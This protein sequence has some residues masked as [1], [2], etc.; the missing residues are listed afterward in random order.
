[1]GVNEKVKSVILRNLYDKKTNVA[2]FILFM[3]YVLFW[4]DTLVRGIIQIIRKGIKI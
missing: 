2:K 1:M 4:L 3:I